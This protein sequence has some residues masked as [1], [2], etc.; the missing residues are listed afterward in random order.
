MSPSG[1]EF[2]S[3]KKTLT[4]QGG[5]ETAIELPRT[6][7]TG[8]YTVELYTS[9]DVLLT[10]D[11]ISVEEFMP[12]RIKV[13][14]ALKKKEYYPGDELKADIRAD[15]LYGTPA[16]ER[17][18]EAELSLNRYYFSSKNSLHIT[19]LF[20]GVK[21]IYLQKQL[22]ALPTIMVKQQRYLMF[23]LNM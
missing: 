18:W 10:T 4:E 8:T 11:Y 13:K 20:M 6:A 12:D 22:K 16:S 21:V 7:I 1:K 19:L 23:H 2:K 5:F 3:V 15:N 17:N 14:S 9:N